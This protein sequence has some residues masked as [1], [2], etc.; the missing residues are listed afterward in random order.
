MAAIYNDFGSFALLRSAALLDRDKKI[1][2]V[3]VLLLVI[4]VSLVTVAISTRVVVSEKL[5]RSH[6]FE[7]INV[8]YENSGYHYVLVVRNGK[9]LE[10][11]SVISFA[12]ENRP[13]E[14]IS[15]LDDL[16]PDENPHLDIYEKTCKNKIFTN[17]IVCGKTAVIHVRNASDLKFASSIP[18]RNNIY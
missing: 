1:L 18:P 6:P 8:V 15:V 16:N 9:E 10:L 2:L 12:D 3:A 11:R 7:N 5:T 13:F 14:R 4:A 17:Q